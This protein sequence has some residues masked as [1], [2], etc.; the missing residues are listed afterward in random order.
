MQHPDTNDSQTNPVSPSIPTDEKLTKIARRVVRFILSTATSE[1]TI[2][3]REKLVKC[4][5]EVSKEEGVSKVQFPKVYPI[6]NQLFYDVLGYEL[7]GNLTK[8]CST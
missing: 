6:V 5:H 3:S 2:F 8:T 1:R 4:I 7:R